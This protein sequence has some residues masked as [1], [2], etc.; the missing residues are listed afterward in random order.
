M[1]NHACSHLRETDLDRISTTVAGKSIKKKPEG[2]QEAK[3]LIVVLKTV[4]A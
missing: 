2:K 1:F 4:A 3:R